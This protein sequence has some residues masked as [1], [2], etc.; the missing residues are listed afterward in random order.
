MVAV[1]LISIGALVAAILDWSIYT[2]LSA[3]LRA[4]FRLDEHIRFR[5]LIK[6][7]WQAAR[8]ILVIAAGGVAGFAF[9][10]R[11]PEIWIVALVVFIFGHSLIYF[12][13]ARR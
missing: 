4:G 7:R 5:D 10:T 12:Y 13:I 11:S 1:A 3:Y 6:T 2:H 9:A 8:F